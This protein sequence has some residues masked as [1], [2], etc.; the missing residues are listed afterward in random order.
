[1]LVICVDTLLEKLSTLCLKIKA[2]LSDFG[3]AVEDTESL[4]GAHLVESNMI[5]ADNEVSTALL[6]FILGRI[7]V[8]FQ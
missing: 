5:A 4:P 8:M 7:V 1:M 2:L 6:L 3:V